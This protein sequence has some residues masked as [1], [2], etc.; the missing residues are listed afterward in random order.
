MSRNET[1][2]RVFVTCNWG[3]NATQLM[4]GY[5][6][7]TPNNDCVWGCFELVD[8]LEE[9]SC[10]L[11]LDGTSVNIPDDKR[12]IFFGREP[13][14]VTSPN[15]PAIKRAE[16]YHH[17]TGNSW[18]ASTWWLGIDYA[19]LKSLSVDD[20]EK[21]RSLSVIESGKTFLLGHQKRLRL[22]R[23]LASEYPLE[24]DIYGHVTKNASGHSYKTEL[25]K[26]SKEKGLLPYRYA[27]SVENGSSKNY[28][29]EKFVDP[30][31]CWSMPIYWG[32]KEIERFFPSGSFVWIDIDDPHAAEKIIEIA[33]SN[34]REENTPR[35]AEARELILDKYNLFPTVEKVLKGEELI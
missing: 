11:M 25:P 2:E 21:T 3:E 10:V 5:R 9:A 17:H 20:V 26:K 27:L 23:K 31:L 14:H 30:I 18:C 35:L 12:V 22:V 29:T 32:C 6:K 34:Y 1:K 15:I 4:E 7:Q 33:N 24:I 19:S 28:F 16:V 13:A 8:K